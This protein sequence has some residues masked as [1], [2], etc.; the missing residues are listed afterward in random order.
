ME[1]GTEV[2]MGFIIVS[3]ISGPPATAW[4][5]GVYRRGAIG[6]GQVRQQFTAEHST[7]QA[8]YPGADAEGV[9]SVRAGRRVQ[10]LGPQGK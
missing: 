6:G 5:L 2:K 3:F 4:L 10:R 9:G 8:L 1:Q 7:G